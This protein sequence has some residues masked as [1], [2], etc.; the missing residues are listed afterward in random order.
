MPFSC[1]KMLKQ[2]GTMLSNPIINAPENML[3]LSLCS[4]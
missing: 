4:I 2:K 3:F 1:R